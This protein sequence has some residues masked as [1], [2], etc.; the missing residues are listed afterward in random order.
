[1]TSNNVVIKF[2]FIKERSTSKEKNVNKKIVKMKINKKIGNED[3]AKTS[4]N[5]LFIKIK[6]EQKNRKTLHIK[7]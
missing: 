3:N 5:L 2:S 7:N 6:N 4:K 1:L